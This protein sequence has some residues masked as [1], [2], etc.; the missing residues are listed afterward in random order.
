MK[1]FVNIWKED[2]KRVTSFKG[3]YLDFSHLTELN[4][5]VEN[6]SVAFVKRDNKRNEFFEEIK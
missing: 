1:A 6:A 5:S 2:N 3:S 4:Q